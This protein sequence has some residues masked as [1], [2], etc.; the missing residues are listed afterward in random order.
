LEKTNERR[1]HIQSAY[2]E[3]FKNIKE[4]EIL[5]GTKKAKN[6]ESLGSNIGANNV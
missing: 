6:S 3:A 4:I 1:R 2:N 5:L